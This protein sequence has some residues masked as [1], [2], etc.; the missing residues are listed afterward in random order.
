MQLVIGRANYNVPET[1]IRQSYYLRGEVIDT[2]API[3][4][5][6]SISES[7]TERSHDKREDISFAMRMK[8]GQK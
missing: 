4:E 5:I 1:F 8:K 7:E 3:S 6:S 2:R